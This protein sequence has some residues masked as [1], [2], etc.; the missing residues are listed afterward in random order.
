MQRKRTNH[1]SSSTD[2]NGQVRELIFPKGLDLDRPKR[3]RT[4]F[5]NEQLALLD[6]NFKRNAYLVGRER[7]ALAEQLGLSET[8]VSVG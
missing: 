6:R 1:E 3:S 8:Q 7:A 2:S 4:T 5:T